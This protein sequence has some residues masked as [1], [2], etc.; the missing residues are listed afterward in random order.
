[1]FFGEQVLLEDRRVG[2]D[3]R[4]RV[5]LAGDLHQP[6]QRLD[7]LALAEVVAEGTP[8][9]GTSWSSSNQYSNSRRVTSE[10][11]G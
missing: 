7:R 1:M 4:L 6:H 8:K 9:P 11:P 5:A 3:E 2:L 10:A